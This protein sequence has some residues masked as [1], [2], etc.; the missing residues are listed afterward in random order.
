MLSAIALFWHD[1]DYKVCYLYSSFVLRNQCHTPEMP[2]TKDA[3]SVTAP[4]FLSLS[5]RDLPLITHTAH[6]SRDLPLI[7]HT[8]HES[9]DL[10]LITHTAHGSL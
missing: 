7:T 6:G 1:G 3:C 8:A 5:R 10:P 4:Y 9:R 2:D